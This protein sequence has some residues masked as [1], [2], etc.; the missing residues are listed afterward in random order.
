MVAITEPTW[1]AALAAEFAAPY[2]K[3][4]AAF[5]DAAYAR[6]VVY[7]PA[8][9][10]FAAF[11]RT[12]L[13]KVKV[14]IIGQDPYHNPDQAHGLA[15]SVPKGVVT[16][17]SL[18]NIYKELESEYGVSYRDRTGD[19]TAWAEQGVLL[20][21]DTL[22]V[23]GGVD[24][25]LSHQKRGWERFTDAAIRCLAAHK[26]LVYMLWGAFAQ[27]K[28]ALVDRATNLVLTSAHPSPLSARRGFFGNGH[29]RACNDY[30]TAHNLSPIKW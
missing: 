27:K 30:L 2:Y 1:H 8:S 13:D 6:E 9:Q 24:T 23:S 18:R 29:F 3:K 5:V 16:P 15:F 10:I 21:N 7:P 12:P 4:L 14:V 26:N 11:N 20:L 17:P 28:A 19:L 22:T 25:A